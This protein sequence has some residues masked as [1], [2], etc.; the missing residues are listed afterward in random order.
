M[1]PR[2]RALVVWTVTLLSVGA[3]AA[4]L[5]SHARG[6][7]PRLVLSGPSY[8]CSIDA[9]ENQ[10]AATEIVAV[11]AL[12]ACAALAITGQVTNSRRLLISAV[13]LPF[14]AVVA[15]VADQWLT[16]RQMGGEFTP[17]ALQ[18][19]VPVLFAVCLAGPLLLAA[20]LGASTVD[21][22]R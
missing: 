12:L 16:V 18:L 5:V 2:A 6:G 15:L 19:I 1:S 3:A 9:C 22:A 17:G 10:F 21:A 7:G 8:Q 14:L 13:P 20:R 11:T 4:Q